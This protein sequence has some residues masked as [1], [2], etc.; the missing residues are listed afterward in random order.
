MLASRLDRPYRAGHSESLNRVGDLG[1]AAER[2]AA[3]GCT[4]EGQ[5]PSSQPIDGDLVGWIATPEAGVRSGP[6]CRSAP[7]DPD[8]IGLRADAVWEFVAATRAPAT[9]GTIQESCRRRRVA[10]QKHMLRRPN[11]TKSWRDLLSQQGFSVGMT[12]SG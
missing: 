2:P 1:S 4:Y 7:L 10:A 3:W 11:M 8:Q 9:Y 5:V 6:R 12:P